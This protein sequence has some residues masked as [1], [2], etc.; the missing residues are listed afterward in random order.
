MNEYTV[1][2]LYE[3]GQRWADSFLADTPQEAEALALAVYDADGSAGLLIAGVVVA[4]QKA[5]GPRV[6]VVA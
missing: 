2:G 1:V 3:N 6:E 5:H 4:V